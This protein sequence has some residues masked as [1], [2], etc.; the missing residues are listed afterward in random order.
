MTWWLFQKQN[1]SYLFRFRRTFPEG[2]IIWGVFQIPARILFSQ[3]QIIKT[4]LIV[5]LIG[6][7]TS[8][9]LPIRRHAHTSNLGYTWSFFGFEISKMADLVTL[10]IVSGMVNPASQATNCMVSIDRMID[11]STQQNSSTGPSSLSDPIGWA[12]SLCGAKTGEV[13]VEVEKKKISAP[14]QSEKPLY[15]RQ[16]LHAT[17][18]TFFTCGWL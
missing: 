16:V 14:L 5:Y 9:G 12:K 10:A 11:L 18:F 3:D 8:S 4:L 6:E 1:R 17:C 13:V 15:L 7:Q 2:N